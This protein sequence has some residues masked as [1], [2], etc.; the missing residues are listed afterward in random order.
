MVMAHLSKSII[1]SS[2]DLLGQFHIVI[3]DRVDY[4]CMH[5]TIGATRG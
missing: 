2:Q 4:S 5:L 1:A 3:A